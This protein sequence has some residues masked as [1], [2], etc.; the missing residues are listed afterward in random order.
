MR[1]RSAILATAFCV[2]GA[3]DASAFSMSFR[4]CGAGPSPIIVVTGV[5]KG[6]TSLQFHMDDLDYSAGNHGG[7]VVAY[8][9]QNT[10]PCGA[11]QTYNPPAP[12]KGSHRYQMSVTALGAGSANLGTAAFT[13]KSRSSSKPYCVDNPRPDCP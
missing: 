7:G 13:Q 1:F 8:N 10:I 3:A 12:P 4:W 9:G 6:T 2:V 11:L 5:P